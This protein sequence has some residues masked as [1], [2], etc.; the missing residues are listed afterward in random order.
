[1]G[2]R[3]IGTAAASDNARTL[4]QT[5]DTVA[6]FRQALVP[7]LT[8]GASVNRSV[9]GAGETLSVSVN[10]SN[11][12][13][14]GTVDLYL[15]VLVPGGAIAFFLPDLSIAVGNVADLGS[16]GRVAT[17]V[18]LSTPFT[19]SRPNIFSRQ[20]AGSEPRGG[21]VLFLLVVKS[22]TLADGIFATD[23]LVGTAIA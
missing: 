16:Y 4:S 15:G 9:F 2:G 18:S 10:L 7:A 22:G 3:P 17:G 12:G 13:S 23:A 1:S 6:N 14:T 11:P 8:L 19:V 21:Y 20:W 5:A